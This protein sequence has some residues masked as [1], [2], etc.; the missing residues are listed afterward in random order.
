LDCADA[1]LR[2]LQQAASDSV[3]K[4]QIAYRKLRGY[5]VQRWPSWKL[6]PEIDSAIGDY[7]AGVSANG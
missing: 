2:E 3:E 4:Q 5:L 7:D 6:P 1:A